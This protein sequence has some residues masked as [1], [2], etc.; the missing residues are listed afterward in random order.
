MTESNVI[1]IVLDDHIKNLESSYNLA[2]L[3]LIIKIKL[4]PAFYESYVKK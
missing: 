2:Y 4:I 1:I 3:R